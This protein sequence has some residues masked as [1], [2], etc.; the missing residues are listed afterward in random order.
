MAFQVVGTGAIDLILV[1]GWVSHLEQMWLQPTYAAYIERLARF[2]RVILFDKRGTGLS[3]RVRVGTLSDRADDIRA[4]MDAV[5]M[6]RAALYA[7]SEGGPLALVFAATQPERVS[8]LVIYGS[9]AR[10]LRG[11]DYGIGVPPEA[12]LQ[13][14]E[15]TERNW[16][17][18]D[19]ERWAPSV[20]ADDEFRGWMA[21]MRRNG[22]SP[23][24]AR[25]LMEVIAEV[26]VRPVLSSISVPTL[27]MHRSADSTVSI[28]M[29]RVI[30]RGITGARWVE[31][32]GADHLP[33]TGDTAALVREIE[34]FLTGQMTLEIPDRVLATIM[35]SNL[36][37]DL[38]R[39]ATTFQEMAV[40]EVGRWGGRILSSGPRRIAASFPSPARA[41]K[42]ARVLQIAVATGGGAFRSGI[43]AGECRITGEGL[44]G[45]PVDIAGRIAL[46]AQRG[47]ILVSNTVRDL[48][49]GSD[50]DLVERGSIAIPG[51]A[52]EWRVF[53]A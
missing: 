21:T 26:D 33:W 4:V 14:T 31:L 13:Q 38:R 19:L 52:A 3:D 49:A 40:Y 46:R 25:E 50:I 10:M 29:G 39:S 20:A 16:P 51:M 30:A 28:E 53:A 18:V 36:D 34:E 41:I 45:P 37:V 32:P 23:G 24:S 43:H 42:C 6:R 44:S 22:A 48:L 35:V 11:E 17:V 47:D 7:I 27:V 8:K 2:A 15:F 12:W 9:F 1:P 5:G